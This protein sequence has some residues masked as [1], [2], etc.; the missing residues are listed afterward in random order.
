[1]TDALRWGILATGGIAHAFTND[2]VRNGFQVQAV[3][4]R[5]QAAADAFAAEFGIPTAHASYEALA[6]DPEVDIIYVSTPHPFHA[7]NAALALNA[8][9]HVLIEKPVAL[10]A[11]EASAIFD[12]A[13]SKNLLALEA[14][15]TR[16]L[17]HMVRIREIIAAGTLGQIRSLLADHTQLLSE[18]PAHR[19]NSLELG[20]GALLD[21][22]IYPVSFASALFGRPE[23]IVAS[24][25]FKKTGADAQVATIFRYAGGQLATTL[26]ASDTRGPNRATILGTQ[27]RVEIDQVWYSPTTFRLLNNDGEVVETF[28]AEV[29]GRGMHFQAVEAEQLVAAGKISSQILPASE[30]VAIM[31]TLD[32]IRAQIGLRYPGE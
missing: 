15:W 3:G 10:N 30:S 27:G 9:K 13:A 14:M 24:A 1:M 29:T 6:A 28:T 20:G 16:F 12:L 7:E 26:S 17:P 11:R 21:L 23:S 5:S 4:S 19:I 22:G 18:D 2:L 25:A 8:G 31:E 32:E